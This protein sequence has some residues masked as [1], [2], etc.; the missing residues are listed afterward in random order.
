L[1]H[2]QTIAI[3]VAMDAVAVELV[4]RWEFWLSGN[5][6]TAAVKSTVNLNTFAVAV[7]A[8]DIVVVAADIVVA[9]VVALYVL[10]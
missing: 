7:A 3:L 5:R 10:T 8:A 4:I 9:D 6:A 2:L 1:D